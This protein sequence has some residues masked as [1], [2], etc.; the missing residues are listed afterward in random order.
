MSK[1]TASTHTATNRAQHMHGWQNP[2]NNTRQV[3]F[4]VVVLI[5]TLLAGCGP[6]PSDEPSEQPSVPLPPIPS[7][8]QQPPEQQEPQDP[9][10]PSQ[11]PPEPSQVPSPVPTVVVPDVVGRTIS[12]ADAL[13]SRLGLQYTVE[14]QAVPNGTVKTGTVLSVE[15][16]AG[17]PSIRS[18]VLTV[19]VEDPAPP[20][21]HTRSTPTR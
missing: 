1:A 5:A 6:P 3:R 16:N 12:E 8:P 9:P 14:E 18:V 7:Q 21:T 10:E 4:S 17:A 20:P 11:N 15:P 19:A 2:R 13:L